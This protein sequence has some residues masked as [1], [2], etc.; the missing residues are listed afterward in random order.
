MRKVARADRVGGVGGVDGV[1]MSGWEDL[2]PNS[3]S[4]AT[5]VCAVF[6]SSGTALGLMASPN[7]RFDF[8]MLLCAKKYK[9][10]KI[11]KY[12]NQKIKI[13]EIKNLDG[14]KD[15]TV[16]GLKDSRHGLGCGLRSDP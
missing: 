1:G 4:M 14:R 16:K 5:C 3:P 13:S 11:Q 7:P 2:D 6:A 15:L 10:T 12:K 9:N 8:V